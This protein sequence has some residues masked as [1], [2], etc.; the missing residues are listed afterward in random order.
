[1]FL[2]WRLFFEDSFLYLCIKNSQFFLKEKKRKN[3]EISLFV[4]SIIYFI[5]ALYWYINWV[6]MSIVHWRRHQQKEIYIQDRIDDTTSIV[7]TE[8]QNLFLF[9]L[10]SFGLI[11]C[12]V[13]VVQFFPCVFIFFGTKLCGSNGILYWNGSAMLYEMCVA[14][15][16][17]I[18]FSR[19]TFNI[20]I[21]FM[22]VK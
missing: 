4:Q 1:M 3:I 11:W 2:F 10:I 8:H 20:N 14:S 12:D 19:T 5:C 17:F 18:K 13:C 15:K 7:L 22:C 16:W 9:E 6:C 21:Y